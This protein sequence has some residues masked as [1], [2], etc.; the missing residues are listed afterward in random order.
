[1]SPGNAMGKMKACNA[2][3]RKKNKQQQNK[4]TMKTWLFLQTHASQVHHFNKNAQHKV[5]NVGKTKHINR[6]TGV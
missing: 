1:M 3:R 4:K 5:L 2:G 6:P